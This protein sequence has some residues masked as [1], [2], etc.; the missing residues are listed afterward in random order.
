MMRAVA[1]PSNSA[2]VQSTPEEASSTRRPNREAYRPLPL[3]LTTKT[4]PSFRNV[5]ILYSDDEQSTIERFQHNLTT[6]RQ[7]LSNFHIPGN[8][9]LT[10]CIICGYFNVDYRSEW[11]HEQQLAFLLK[12]PNTYREVAKKNL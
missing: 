5:V 2:L 12:Q 6:Y 10:D 8:K 4:E 11:P 9:Q 1:T 7:K 3:Y